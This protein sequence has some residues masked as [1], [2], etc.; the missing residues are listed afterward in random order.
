MTFTRHV[1][2][3]ERVPAW[4]ECSCENW[5]KNATDWCPDCKGRKGWWHE[6]VD[7]SGSG[8]PMIG[9]PCDSYG[10]KMWINVTKSSILVREHRVCGHCD[11]SKIK[12]IMAE[13]LSRVYTD[14]ELPC[15]H[16]HKD[17][18]GKPTGAEA[19]TAGE[20]RVNGH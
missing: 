9:L 15:D 19:G 8:K 17:A 11:G 4:V 1:T 12:P 6:A 7:L 5:N 18:D 16:C 3:R 2:I 10:G 14:I 13:S 20:W